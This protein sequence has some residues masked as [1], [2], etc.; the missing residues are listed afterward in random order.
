MQSLEGEQN[1][2]GSYASLGARTVPTRPGTVRPLKGPARGA[3]A[4]SAG[5][6]TGPYR[7]SRMGSTEGLGRRSTGLGAKR[8]MKR[9]PTG[10]AGVRHHKE[11]IRSEPSPWTTLLAVVSPV[12]LRG[13]HTPSRHSASAEFPTELPSTRLP[14]PVME[15]QVGVPTR[16]R[17]SGRGTGRRG[18]YAS[19]YMELAVGVRLCMAR[20]PPAGILPHARQR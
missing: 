11:G 5:I 10:L 9:S 13:A 6:L 2:S 16:R 4:K 7:R 3:M 12:V 1:S 14:V 19:V 15:R 20:K 17:A 18:A 8:A